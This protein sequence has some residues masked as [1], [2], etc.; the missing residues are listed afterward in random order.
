MA[1]KIL[2]KYG[3]GTPLDTDISGPGEIAIDIQNKVIYTKDAGDNIVML[4]A[5]VSASLIDWSQLQNVPTEFN[6][7]DHTHEYTEVNDGAGKTLDVEIA[8]ILAHLASIDSELGSLAGNLTFA[9]TVQM[10]TGVI[11]SV[12]AAGTAVGFTTGSI[13]VDPP[14]GSVNLYF[15]C[16]NGGSFDGSVYNGGDWLV[17]EGNGNGWAGIHFDSS[18]NVLWDDVGNKPTEFP[19]E[20]HTHII[21]EVTGLQAELDDK[22]DIGHSHVIADITDLQAELDSKANMSVINGGTY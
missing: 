2:L 13:P 4:G 21:A 6:P 19:P 22:T 7:A 3:Q 20:A 15:V 9:G 12:T 17:S 18:V 8:A 16:E 5:D 10:A 14:V 1:T 11:T